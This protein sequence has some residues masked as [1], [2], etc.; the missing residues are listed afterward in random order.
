MDFQRLYEFRHRQVEQPGR[1]AVWAAIADDLFVRM[2][3]PQIVLDPACGKGEFISAVPAQERW[4]VDL[5]PSVAD[6]EQL[7]IH[8]IIGD[9]LEVD[10]PPEHFVGVLLSN[11]LEHLMTY[12]DVQRCLKRMHAVI[13]PGGVVA[14]LG[15]NFK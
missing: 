9:M 12:E 7:G 8:T 13:R 4:A 1:G 5:M 15:P 3:K 2:G 10:L 6:L 11:V 14:V